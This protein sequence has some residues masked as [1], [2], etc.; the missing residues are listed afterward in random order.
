MREA[1]A[2]KDKNI[3]FI[4]DSIVCGHENLC[5]S[6]DAD[7]GKAVNEDGTRAFAYLTSEL[8][9]ADCSVIGCSGI[10]IDKGFTNF[11][12]DDFYPKTSYYILLR[13]MV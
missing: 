8:L 13:K 11:S 9:G 12:E 10:G 6:G 2:N 1:P 5:Q 7:Q 3:E 4:G